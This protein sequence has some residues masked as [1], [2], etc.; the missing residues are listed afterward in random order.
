MLPSCAG[1]VLIVSAIL[2]R[3]DELTDL[4][5]TRLCAEAM[6]IAAHENDDGAI[7]FLESGIHYRKYDP[8]HDDAQ[9]FALEGWLIE[10]GYLTYE[11]GNHLFY[12][13][14]LET[15]SNKYSQDFT[16]N[17]G[18]KKAL[19]YC[20]AKMQAAK[21]AALSDGGHK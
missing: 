1:S 6:G 20:V 17:A 11:D 14:P 8:L 21:V 12:T 4:E 9:C 2:N 3:S 13:W 15:S 10:R 19:V 7:R 16:D 18:R 5:A